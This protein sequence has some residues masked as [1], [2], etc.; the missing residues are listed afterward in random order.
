MLEEGKAKEI[1]EEVKQEKVQEIGEAIKSGKKEVEMIS[2]PKSMYVSLHN[3][4][5][6][7]E[8][9][10]LALYESLKQYQV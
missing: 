10:K 2:V 7:N 9:E 5:I 4:F 1:V 8:Q 6:M 3:Y